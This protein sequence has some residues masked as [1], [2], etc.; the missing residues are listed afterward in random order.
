VGAATAAPTPSSGGDVGCIPPTHP[1]RLDGAPSAQNRVLGFWIRIRPPKLS[2]F[3][4]AHQPTMT[5]I[6]LH[7]FEIIFLIFSTRVS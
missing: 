7:F 2:I 3:T 6:T 4:S 5:H 1:R